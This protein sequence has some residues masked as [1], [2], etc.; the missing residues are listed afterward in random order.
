M[1]AVFAVYERRFKE[2]HNASPGLMAL[3]LFGR[4]SNTIGSSR[5][6]TSRGQHRRM[7]FV[8][9]HFQ[10]LATWV[11]GKSLASTF[12]VLQHEGSTSSRSITS[13]RTAGVGQRR[14]RQ[15]FEDAVFTDDQVYEGLPIP[16]VWRR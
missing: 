5:S 14:H 16:G 8:Q 1:D 3:Y 12:S 11:E 6:T 15:Y 4:R 2:Y 10:G 9:P 13:G 7:F